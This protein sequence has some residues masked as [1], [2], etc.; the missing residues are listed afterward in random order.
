M[1]SE[2]VMIVGIFKP[3]KNSAPS[4]EVQTR[5]TGTEKLAENP[6]PTTVKAN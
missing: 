5:T 2:F 4:Q 3:L 6:N 1:I